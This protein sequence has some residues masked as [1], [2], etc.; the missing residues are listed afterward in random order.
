MQLLLPPVAKLASPPGAGLDLRDPKAS[1][2]RP[3]E[4]AASGG[5]DLLMMRFNFVSPVRWRMSGVEKARRR[6]AA[7][8]AGP[9]SHWSGHIRYTFCEA[10]NA[11]YDADTGRPLTRVAHVIKCRERPISVAAALALVWRYSAE[12]SEWVDEPPDAA[13]RAARAALGSGRD[14][15]CRVTIGRN[16]RWSSRSGASR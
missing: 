7:I 15:S 14:L 8:A 2:E 5:H 12:I 6:R 10:L 3:L 16:R 11:Y 4:I 9:E 1:V 13:I